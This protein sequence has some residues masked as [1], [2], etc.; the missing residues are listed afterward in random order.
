MDVLINNNKIAVIK[1]LLWSQRMAKSLKRKVNFSVPVDPCLS[2]Y[3][4]YIVCTINVQLSAIDPSQIAFV[5]HV[6]LL[7][8]PLLSQN[9]V[10]SLNYCFC[11][12]FCTICYWVVFHSKLALDL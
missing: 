2:P 12:P 5:P 7:P 10:A 3:S 11:I 8:V 9:I 4:L 1:A 6:M